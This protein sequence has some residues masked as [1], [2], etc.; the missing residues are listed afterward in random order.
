MVDLVVS[1]RRP[2]AA[3]ARLSANMVVVL[4]PAPT[5]ATM[6]PGAAMLTRSTDLSSRR[7]I[8]RDPTVR[9]SSA[10]WSADRSRRRSNR[11]A[12]LHPPRGDSALTICARLPPTYSVP[13]A[14]PTRTRTSWR[15]GWWTRICAASTPTA[16]PA[17]PS[18][19][20]GSPRD[21]STRAR[22]RGWFPTRQPPSWSMART[23][24]G[25][26]CATSPSTPPSS[27]PRPTALAGRVFASPTTTAPRD[28]GRCA[29]HGPAS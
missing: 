24:W 27:A 20:S 9:R 13:P 7:G 16:S 25:T 3:S 5:M 14:L 19:W 8:S 6:S 17:S 4:P 23:A 22:G 18:I 10:V 2:V 21:S 28:I 15:T 11:W 1:T 26:S 29:A 12:R